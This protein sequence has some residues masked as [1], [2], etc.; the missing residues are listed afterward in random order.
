MRKERRKKGGGEK[1]T[2][3]RET[4]E[5]R[6]ALGGFPS[7]TYTRALVGVVAG[8]PLVRGYYSVLV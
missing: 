7:G 5:L 4:P 6:A 3:K 1:E 2:S 8:P